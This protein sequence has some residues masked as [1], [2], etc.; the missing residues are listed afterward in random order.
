VH[1]TADVLNKL[2]KAVQPKVKEALHDIWMAETCENAHKAFETALTRFNAKYPRTMD[3]LAKDRENMLTF[4]DFPAEH[5][6]CLTATK[7]N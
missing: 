3:G 2:P 7:L 5:W 4:Y 6:A 1:K